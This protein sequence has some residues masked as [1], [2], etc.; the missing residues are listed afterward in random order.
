MLDDVGLDMNPMQLGAMYAAALTDYS[1][2]GNLTIH[3]GTTVFAITDKSVR[4]F[5]QKTRKPLNIECDKVIIALGYESKNDLA[6]SLSGYEG[7]TFVIGDAVKPS[8][9]LVAVHQANRLASRV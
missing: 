1:E 2:K 9:I 7:E 6:K 8:K 5:N 3:T 4:A